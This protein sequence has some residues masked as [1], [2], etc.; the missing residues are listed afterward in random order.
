MQGGAGRLLVP[1][2]VGL[3]LVLALLGKIPLFRLP[4][5]LRIQI[6]GVAFYVPLA[7]CLVLSRC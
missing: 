5:V 7:T 1:V 6:G 2:G 3:L 4:G